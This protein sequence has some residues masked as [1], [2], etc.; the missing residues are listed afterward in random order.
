M[1]LTEGGAAKSQ[2]TSCART[3][4][5]VVT[6]C[7]SRS[8]RTRAHATAAT[9]FAEIDRLSVKKVRTG[10]PSDAVELVVVDMAGELVPR[11]GA[12]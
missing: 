4:E 3:N 2:P 12:Q 6:G 9:A 10:A 7:R 8:R 5:V 1:R 11:R